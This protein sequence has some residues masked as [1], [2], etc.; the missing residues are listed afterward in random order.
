MSDM[1]LIEDLYRL[2]DSVLGFLTYSRA[3]FLLSSALISFFLTI[4]AL[5]IVNS[6]KDMYSKKR[7]RPVLI[8]LILP[9]FSVILSLY[10]LGIIKASLSYYTPLEYIFGY[11]LYC[12]YVFILMIGSNRRAFSSHLS[13][14]TLVL[15]YLIGLFVL[16]Q[17]IFQ[18]RLGVAVNEDTLD[19]LKLS[20]DGH[21]YY[22]FHAIHYDVAPMHTYLH[23][24]IAYITGLEPIAKLSDTLI[25]FSLWL[26]FFLYMYIF[27]KS[28][29]ANNLQYNV[30]LLALLPALI[31][32]YPYSFGGIL[33][34]LVNSVS[35][36]P[37]LL[38]V[39]FILVKLTSHRTVIF[40]ADTI[41]A[42][43][44]ILSSILMHP[45]GFTVL[46]VSIIAL[47]LSWIF[48]MDMNNNIRRYL[49]YILIYAIILFI[50]KALY[51]GLYYGLET[52]LS[53]ISKA[54]FTSLYLLPTE[55]IPRKYSYIPVSSL[56][57]YSFI[58]GVL[59]AL[60]LYYL[61]KAFI[62]K[63]KEWTDI[64][65]T[66]IIA[67]TLLLSFLSYFI[68]TKKEVSK[69]I[70]GNI[71]SLISICILI[72][73]IKFLKK[74]SQRL[75]GLILFTLMILISSF[76]TLTS[77]LVMFSHYRISQG[78]SP[79]SD[80]DYMVATQVASLLSD[81]MNRYTVIYDEYWPY[82]VSTAMNIA[83]KA[84][85][86]LRNDSNIVSSQ[87]KIDF[88]TELETND[89][90]VYNGWKILLTF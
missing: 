83:L 47:L 76:G 29:L 18:V 3:V 68:V 70:V 62:R 9:L 32:I 38:L 59:V 49:H 84:H 11:V 23:V 10:I 74:N 12:A 63:R 31:M 26:S 28:S 66:T 71:V 2:L 7:L 55:V 39:T 42:M 37:I 64:F 82:S 67:V 30:W 54:L 19:I 6:K 60:L 69:Y 21:L 16:A 65:N 8:P 73:Y 72:E 75:L 17:R 86:L 13:K 81:S 50:I 57:S 1:F 4:V 87:F 24:I 15:T 34:G 33:T 78:A 22:S 40:K 88:S 44:F 35:L 41:L 90:I 58:F 46:F 77:P 89:S 25:T 20:M 48:N 61:L 85:R 43:I 56:Y 53:Y 80:M 51:T 14:I 27:V 45:I 36:G 79:A 5:T 52:F